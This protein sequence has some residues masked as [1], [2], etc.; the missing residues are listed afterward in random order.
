MADEFSGTSNVAVVSI[1]KV[2]FFCNSRDYVVI[3]SSV[4]LFIKS[5]REN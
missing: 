1:P 3:V 2:E 4:C 5:R